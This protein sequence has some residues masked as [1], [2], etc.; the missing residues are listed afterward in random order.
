VAGSKI[1]VKKAESKQTTGNSRDAWSES[2]ARARLFIILARI[3]SWLRLSGLS[4]LLLVT[5]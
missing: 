5:G 1:R 2:E 3:V 4:V